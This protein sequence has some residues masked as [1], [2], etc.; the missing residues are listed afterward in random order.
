VRN[1]CKSYS[2]RQLPWL[3][4]PAC[5]LFVLI[6]WQLILNENIRATAAVKM[7]STNEPR[8]SSLPDLLMPVSI[9]LPLHLG[10]ALVPCPASFAV[11]TKHVAS[12][13]AT[14]TCLFGQLTGARCLAIAKSYQK[15]Q[16]L[17]RRR[18]PWQPVLPARFC[19]M[20]RRLRKNRLLTNST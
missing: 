2:Y 19:R 1:A 20:R 14:K 13:H 6:K 12:T 9:A 10:I 15:Q 5:L 18:F 8:S 16:V 4:P 11:Q 3:P 7:H 17:P